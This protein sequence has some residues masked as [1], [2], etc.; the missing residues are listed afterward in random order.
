M[1]WINRLSYSMA[2]YEEDLPK[3]YLNLDQNKESARKEI[4]SSACFLIGSIES[5][6]QKI[7][8]LDMETNKRNHEDSDLDENRGLSSL[9][10]DTQGRTLKAEQIQQKQS[11]IKSKQK[12]LDKFTHRYEHPLTNTQSDQHQEMQDIG[13]KKLKSKPRLIELYQFSGLSDAGPTPLPYGIVLDTIID[14]VVSAHESTGGKICSPKE[15]CRN[16]SS[17]IAKEIILGC[18]WWIYLHKYKPDTENQ[19]Q[20]FDR[21]AENYIKL[22]GITFDQHHG[23]AFLKVFPSVLSQAIYSSFCFSF[24][25]SLY[26]FQSD[27][28]RTQLC[29]LLWQWIGGIC[30]SPGCYKTWDF[31]ILEPKND[32]VHGKEKQKQGIRNGEGEAQERFIKI[33]PSRRQPATKESHP[34][35][36]GPAFTH[37]LFNLSGHSPLVQYYLQE[38]HKKPR[39]GLNILVHRTEIKNQLIKQGFQRLHKQEIE[40]NNKFRKRWKESLEFDRSLQNAK[41]EYL[42]EEKQILSHKAEMKRISQQIFSDTKSSDGHEEKIKP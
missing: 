26:R 2:P 17:L 5:V 34:A 7:A 4:E 32:M 37:K 1:D 27:D 3:E 42:K 15:V 9:V 35:C 14:R 8:H 29:N 23:E 6:N 24:P 41:R 18:F 33:T 19:K 11:V 10:Q 39:A 30:P 28:F 13:N 16:L 40:V 36:C 12:V 38:H 22:L 20:L 25:Q 21:V 31:H